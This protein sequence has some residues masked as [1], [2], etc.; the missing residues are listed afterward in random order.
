MK[1]IVLKP[2]VAFRADG[3]SVS[4]TAKPEPQEVDKEIAEDLVK[5]GKA[6][7]PK[8]IGRKTTAKKADA[9]GE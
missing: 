9:D 2:V 1:I 5:S 6:E 4:L 8:T 7:K 3:T